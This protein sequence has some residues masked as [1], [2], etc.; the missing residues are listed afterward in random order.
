MN[1]LLSNTVIGINLNE[2]WPHKKQYVLNRKTNKIH[3]IS[4]S[5]TFGHTLY[6]VNNTLVYCCTNVIMYNNLIL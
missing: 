3:I 2:K 4:S 5:L 1:E 6:S